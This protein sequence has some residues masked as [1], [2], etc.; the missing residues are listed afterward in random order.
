[1]PILAALVLALL[2]ALLPSVAEAAPPAQVPTSAHV[3]A[4]PVTDPYPIQVQLM[5]VV[6]HGSALAGHLVELPP[7]R[8]KRIV[9]GSLFVIADSRG[10][11]NYHSYRPSRWDRVLVWLPT[12]AGL[13]KGQ[14]VVVV[15]TVRTVRGAQLSGELAG[16]KDDALKRYGNATLLVADSVETPDGESLIRR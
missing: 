16:L 13:S 10:H 12:T 6:D 3:P 2:P 14:A 11:G 8:I 9:N 4:N 15:G 7:A 1:M 5:T